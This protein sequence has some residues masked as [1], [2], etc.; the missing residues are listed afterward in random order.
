MDFKTHNNAAVDIDSSYL[1]E[2]LD[3]SFDDLCVVFGTPLVSGMNDMRVEW[4][5][6]FA[7][8]TVA[9]IY[10]WQRTG[11]VNTNRRWNIGGF[12]NQAVERVIDT[13]A[14]TLAGT[15]RVVNRLGRAA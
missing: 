4:H 5:I 11:P 13:I 7:D 15:R 1:Q 8:G 12:S 6:E 3:I 2:V 14:T 9:T 10:D